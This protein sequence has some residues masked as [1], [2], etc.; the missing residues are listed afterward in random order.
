MTLNSL[1][2]KQIDLALA[3]MS[4]MLVMYELVRPLGFISSCS[5]VKQEAKKKK[6]KVLY[7]VARGR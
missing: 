6:K 4:D 5:K 2:P 1:T 3:Y 7:F